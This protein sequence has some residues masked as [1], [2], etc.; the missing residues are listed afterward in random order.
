[1]NTTSS[2]L[3]RSRAALLSQRSL[4]VTGLCA[5]LGACGGGD[6]KSPVDITPDAA[7]ADVGP[8]EDANPNADVPMG[9][10]PVTDV[11]PSVDAT[12][13]DMGPTGPECPPATG[14]GLLANPVAITS[15]AAGAHSP[16]AVWNGMEWGVVSFAP[17]GNNVGDVQFQRVNAMGQPVGA[18]QTLG[19]ARLPKYEVAWNGGGYVI[20]WLGDRDPVS[21]F[22]GIRV[23]LTGSDGTPI[24]APT[25]I[26][27][28]FDADRI[29]L[30]WAQLSGGLVLFTRGNA[31]TGGLFAQT[32]DEGGQTFGPSVT[33]SPTRATSPHVVFGNGNWG[34]AWL[35]PGANSLFDLNFALLG[36]NGAVDR[37]SQL[38]NNAGAQSGIS[39]AYGNDTFGLGWSHVDEA[40][41]VETRLSIIAGDGSVQA[42]PTVQ[43]ATG[44]SVVSDVTWHEP[45][46]FG[47]A[48]DDIGGGA[49]RVGVTRIN[50]VG[51]GLDPVTI[52][53]PEGAVAR[54][55]NSAGTVSNLGVFYTLDPTPTP[56][57]ISAGAQVYLGRIGA[58][59]R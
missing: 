40:G 4:L 16:R 10:A 34:A 57:G 50:T 29:A 11:G 23:Q 30:G 39:L 47:V 1:M 15:N 27:D 56:S 46:F 58:C 51:V 26:A 18:S 59:R 41:T 24:D 14:Y 44:I 35:T 12:P 49:Q 7:A 52:D 43:G 3:L 13:P 6:S 28:T 45:E 38:P 2:S 33:L 19:R 9:G 17:A 21:G 5:A 8:V 36:E 22:T 55:A 42:T 53:P 54:S 31:G 25:E 37:V 32:L 20:A 48:W